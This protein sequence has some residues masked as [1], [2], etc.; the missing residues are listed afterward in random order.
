MGVLGA[1]GKDTQEGWWVGDEGF[2]GDDEVDPILVVKLADWP[3]LFSP[4]GLDGKILVRV[5]MGVPERTIGASDDRCRRDVLLF[6]LRGGGDDWRRNLT[7][8][9][10]YLL[11]N[12]AGSCRLR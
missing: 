3:P 7:W 2:D 1:E 5:V 12:W 8:G 4:A 11:L 6:F 10:S 9:R